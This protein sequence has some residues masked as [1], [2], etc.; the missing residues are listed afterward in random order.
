MG[1][2]DS[3]PQ[4][5]LNYINDVIVDLHCIAEPPHGDLSELPP[6]VHTGCGDWR[7]RLAPKGTLWT[8]LRTP[9]DHGGN[10]STFG[11]HNRTIKDKH[12]WN[13]ASLTG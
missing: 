7:T 8:G 4:S 11:S 2:T 5:T 3:E 10:L 6:Q 12:R 9:Q 13:E 1:A